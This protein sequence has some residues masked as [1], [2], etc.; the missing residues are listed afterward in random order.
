[1][2]KYS[3]KIV[4][5]M[6][7]IVAFGFTIYLMV[8]IPSVSIRSHTRESTL[9]KLAEL[10]TSDDIREFASGK[11]MMLFNSTEGSA[12]L[13]RAAALVSLLNAALFTAAVFWPVRSNLDQDR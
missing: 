1:M 13:L 11:I 12:F 9:A 2:S 4:C 3:N 7:L 6:G 5:V 8:A 10:T